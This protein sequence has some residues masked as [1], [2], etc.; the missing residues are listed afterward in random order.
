MILYFFT[1][2]LRSIYVHFLLNSLTSQIFLLV[3][4]LFLRFSLNM[5]E[6]YCSGHA[7]ARTLAILGT[8]FVPTAAA[9]GIFADAHH[10]RRSYLQAEDHFQVTQGSAGESSAIIMS[11]VEKITRQD[12]ILANVMKRLSVLEAES[13]PPEGLSPAPTSLKKALNL[14][15]TRVNSDLDIER[16]KSGF[17]LNEPGDKIRLSDPINL[18]HGVGVSTEVEVFS[19]V[20]W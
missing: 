20:S 18:N 9:C 14:D 19:N 1:T 8:I 12:Q 10:A 16:V 7:E 13:C 3:L 2:S 11:L 5:T 15:I 6:L 4:I 17:R